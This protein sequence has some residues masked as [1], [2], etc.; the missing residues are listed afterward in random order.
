MIVA[1]PMYFMLPF[2]SV[3]NSPYTAQAT[4]FHPEVQE[5]ADRILE[6]CKDRERFYQE[7]LINQAREYVVD[8]FEYETDFER[9]YRNIGK[10]Y[11]MILSTE[12]TGDC[13]DFSLTFCSIMNHVDISCIIRS[14]NGAHRIA[15]VKIDGNKWFVIEPQNLYQT[16]WLDED[17]FQGF[18]I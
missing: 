13:I 15:L 8:N 2:I 1:N 10:T 18:L 4:D 17:T 12:D 7:C 6:E 5:V 3:A 11:N 14:P 16:G 9:G